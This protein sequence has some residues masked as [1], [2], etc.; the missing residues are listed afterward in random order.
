VF[1]CFGSRQVATRRCTGP[2]HAS[3]RLVSTDRPGKVEMLTVMGWDLRALG[4]AQLR[5][6]TAMQRCI[7]DYR[8]TS[9]P[10]AASEI[11]RHM[12][13]IEERFP[14]AQEALNSL[15]QALG[16]LEPG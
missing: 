4:E 9:D 7:E 5:S 16:E 3:V 6:L 13:D 15:R 11:R 14:H 1:A 12:G 2:I 8:K 10:H